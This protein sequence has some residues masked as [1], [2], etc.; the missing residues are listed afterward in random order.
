MEA[1]NL[2]NQVLLFYASK[3]PDLYAMVHQF[4]HAPQDFDYKQLIETLNNINIKS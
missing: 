3:Q 2:T 1:Q 4:N